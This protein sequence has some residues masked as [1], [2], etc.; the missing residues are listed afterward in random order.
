MSETTESIKTE[1]MNAYTSYMIHERD[2]PNGYEANPDFLVG[3]LMYI[4]GINL[5][6]LQVLQEGV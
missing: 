4:C 6:G 2:N 1:A 3:Q 5:D